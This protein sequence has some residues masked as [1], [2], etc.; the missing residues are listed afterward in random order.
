MSLIRFQNR[1]ADTSTGYIEHF[2]SPGAAEGVMNARSLRG[3]VGKTCRQEAEF[4]DILAG[5]GVT[6]WMPV[7]GIPGYRHPLPAHKPEIRWMPH[8]VGSRAD[9]V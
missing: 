6:Q 5:S 9:N 7:R 3:V 2:H 4:R 1:V 8:S